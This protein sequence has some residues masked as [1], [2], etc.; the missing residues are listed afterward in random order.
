VNALARL[1]GRGRDALV[2]HL[3]DRIAHDD[4][5]VVDASRLRQLELPSVELLV[6]QDEMQVLRSQRSILCA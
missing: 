5:L 6:T 3:E 2:D 1:L 4:V